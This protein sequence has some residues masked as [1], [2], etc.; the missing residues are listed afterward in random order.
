MMWL[1]AAREIPVSDDGSPPFWVDGQAIPVVWIIGMAGLIAMIFFSWRGVVAVRRLDERTESFREFAALA[2][3]SG[4]SVPEILALKRI[5]QLEKLST[6][7]TLLV[8]SAT[9]DHHL[10]SAVKKVS[11]RKAKP[12]RRH[13]GRIM[14]RLG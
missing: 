11:K 5:A 7:L 14:D 12:L 3:R 8:C 13:A 1:L 10:S 4:L 9:L 6:P 2:R